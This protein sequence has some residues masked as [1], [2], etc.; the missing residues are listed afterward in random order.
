MAALY[1]AFFSWGSC[2]IKVG[3]YGLYAVKL[4]KSSI[5]ASDND[6]PSERLRRGTILP[7]FRD[8]VDG[9]FFVLC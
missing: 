4:K 7:L 2:P 8:R 9:H 6:H 3:A 5:T 1:E